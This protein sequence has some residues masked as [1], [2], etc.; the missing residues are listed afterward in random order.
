MKRRRFITLIGSAAAAWPISVLAQVPHKRPLLVWITGTTRASTTGLAPFLKGMR[1]LGYV[2]A[3]ICC[4]ALCL[5]LAQSGHGDRAQRCPLSGLK[6]TSIGRL[7]R[8]TIPLAP[9]PRLVVD[10]VRSRSSDCDRHSNSP[11][12]C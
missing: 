3:A 5:L 1:E 9:R 11:A 4:G 7:I 10:A 12:P 8:S 6:R 2:E